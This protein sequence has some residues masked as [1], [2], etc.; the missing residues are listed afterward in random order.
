MAQMLTSA[1][2]RRPFARADILSRLGETIFL[3]ELEELTLR[4]PEPCRA[5]P[6]VP[7][8]TPP[9]IALAEAWDEDPERWD[10]MS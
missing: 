10:G 2:R 3:A 5:S 4:H 9:V 1:P 7:P 8:A 6:P